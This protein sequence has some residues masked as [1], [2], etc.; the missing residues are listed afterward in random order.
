MSFPNG[1]GKKKLTEYK[2]QI[3]DISQT[4]TIKKTHIL[5]SVDCLIGPLFH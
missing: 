5:V 2:H 3:T 4:T 1:F